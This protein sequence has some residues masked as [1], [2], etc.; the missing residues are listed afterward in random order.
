MTD[1]PETLTL[2]VVHKA[3]T[4]DFNASDFLAADFNTLFDAH[5]NINDTLTLATQTQIFKPDFLQADFNF[6]DFLS[7]DFASLASA[8]TLTLGLTNTLAIDQVTNISQTLTLELI[9][10]MNFTA[11]VNFNN[12]LTLDLR[13]SIDVE[14]DQTANIYN[15]L[16]FTLYN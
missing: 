4:A 15:I 14:Q 8:Y 13:G 6:S 16:N 9:T 7:G 10:E 5:L 11:F 3:F 2:G 1:F 12:T